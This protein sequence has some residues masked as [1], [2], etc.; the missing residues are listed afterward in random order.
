MAAPPLTRDLLDTF[1]NT[2]G[3]SPD[4]GLETTGALTLDDVR[5]FLIPHLAALLDRNLSFLMHVLYRVDV[6]EAAV[7]RVFATVPP[8][9]IPGHL[10]D[11]LIERQLQKC[12]TRRA[13]R[14]ENP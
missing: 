11:L 10:A 9:D 1:S 6:D 4:A 3:V 12:R 2:L 7:R 13:H 5:R 14:E 8:G